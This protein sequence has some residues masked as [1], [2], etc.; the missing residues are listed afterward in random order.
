MQRRRFLK[1]LVVG[2]PALAMGLRAAAQTWNSGTDASQGTDAINHSGLFGSISDVTVQTVNRPTPLAPAYIS[3]DAD[4]SLMAAW[5]L[6][7][8]VRNPRPALN[9]EPVF[10]V[11]PLHV[12][13][14]PEG[15]DPIVPGDT[16]CRMDWEFMYMREITGSRYG[17]D[18]QK[19]LRQRILGYVQDDGLAWVTP[20]ARMEGAVYGGKDV[21]QEK[22]AWPWTTGKILL[23]L[24]ET[25]ARTGDVASRKLARKMFLALQRLASWD[26]GRAYFAGHPWHG[27]DRIGGGPAPSAALEPIVRYWETTGDPEALKLSMDLADGMIASAELEAAADAHSITSRLYVS[28]SGEFHGH[29]HS[30]LNS[31]WGVAH[32]GTVQANSRYINWAKEVYDYAAQ[33]GTGTGWMSA[34]LWDNPV[35]EQ[36]ETCAT[37]DMIS[38]ASLIARAGFSDYWD[39]VERMFRNY[40]QPFQFFATQEYE[41]M[42]RELNK[43]KGEAEVRAGL[44]RMGELQGALWGGPAPNDRIN[45]IA[46]SKQ[47]GPYGTPFGIAALY[48][49][50]MAEG[51]RA[52]Y[53]VWSSVVTANREG[54][55][56]NLSLN[57]ESEWARVISSLPEQGRIDV[58]PHKPGSYFLRTPSWAP[59]SKVRVARG[60]REIP[61][62]WGGPGLGYVHLKAVQ[63][64]EVLTLVYPLVTQKQVIG[65]WPTKPDLKLTILWNGNTVNDMEPRGKGLPVRFS[66]RE[67]VP[68]LQA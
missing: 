39:H 31:V 35:R 66:K 68:P 62:E 37:A 33:F 12:P 8:L 4:L 44:V 67:P 28:P 7:H 56:V 14:A 2:T 25:Y 22:E 65:I 47:Y 61:V 46:S 57:R 9:Y 21:P 19:A 55:F 23:S 3:P 45:W 60:G 40:V 16:D 18:V 34:A 64:K 20:G 32:L 63:P 15:H 42:Y 30:T 38:L 51:M 26:S 1:S 11:R 59:R 53:T 6:R 13:P 27:N 43:D 41:A 48:G 54:I 29:M 17:L 10:M 49:C 52:L 50:C 24:S 58:I 5:A 36:S